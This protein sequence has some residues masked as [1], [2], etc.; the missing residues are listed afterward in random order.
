M[1]TK[2]FQPSK[3]DMI[4]KLRQL[5]EQVAA[6][7]VVVTTLM[8]NL[9]VEDKDKGRVPMKDYVKNGKHT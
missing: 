2:R 6:L 5:E 7:S 3:S 1:T 4:A 8:E 9:Y